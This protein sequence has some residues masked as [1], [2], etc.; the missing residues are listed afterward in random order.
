MS[1]NEAPRFG[2]TLEDVGRYPWQ[3]VL[4]DETEK[5]CYHFSTAFR[6]QAKPAQERGDE[7]GVRVYGF[8]EV[9]NHFMLRS[10]DDRNPYVPQWS[11]FEG[12]RSLQ[13]DDLDDQ[14]LDLLEGIINEIEDPEFRARVADVLWVT[15]KDFRAAQVA[16]EAFVQS[17]ERLKEGDNW[18]P[19]TERLDRAAHISARKGFE[20]QRE[21]VVSSVEAAFS[22]FK[23]NQETVFLCHR[24]MQILLKLDEGDIEFYAKAAEDLAKR[25]ERLN[26]WRP[27]Q[28]YWRAAMAWH[29]RGGNVDDVHRCKLAAA[30]C[31]VSNAEG[32]IASGKPSLMSAAHWMS[33]G[34]E[35]LR[36]AKADPKR[37]KEVHAKLLKVQ[38]MSTEELGQIRISDE[39]IKDMEEERKRVQQACVDLVSGKSF[40]EALELFAL[41]FQPTDYEALKKRDAETADSSVLFRLIGA[42]IIDPSGKVTANIP[43]SPPGD[44]EDPEVTR[45]RLVQGARNIDWIMAVDWRI[46]PV[47]FQILQEHA[48][49]TGDLWFLVRDNPFIEPGHEG[50]YLQGVQAGFFGDWLVAMHLLVPQMESSIRFVLNQ[51]GV[52]T[53]NMN[54]EGIQEDFDLNKLLWMEEVEAIFGPNILFDLRGI[55][56][57]RVGCNLRN[58]LAHGLMSEGAFY[59]AEA[60]Y[61]W[62]LVIH[63]LYIGHINLKRFE[64]DSETPS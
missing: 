14:D 43:G 32:I 41:A 62:W 35:A 13:P 2:I 57:E 28:E 34:L 4:R 30:E 29:Q 38:E 53:S 42:S 31:D 21:Q 39:K 20:K 37:I 59:I 51:Q 60:P 56:I 25:F 36:Q 48:I 44:P 17:A 47:R 3:K 64:E 45:K 27:A 46:E 23:D 7:L 19:F 33:R 10:E 52:I 49:R 22:E 8:F 1:E 24:L 54:S 26:D 11:G 61:F 40:E 58:E 9:L 15:R 55:L 16:V 6:K 63:L 50:I 18:S 5:E 12:K